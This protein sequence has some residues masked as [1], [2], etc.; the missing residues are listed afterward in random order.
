MGAGSLH[1]ELAVGVAAAA[2]AAAQ[3]SIWRRETINLLIV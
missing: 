2:A 1:K 3:Q